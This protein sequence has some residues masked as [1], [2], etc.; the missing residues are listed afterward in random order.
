M[1][2]DVPQIFVVL[3]ICTIST[4]G[5]SPA[6]CLRSNSQRQWA[7]LLTKIATR[8]GF[9]QRTSHVMPRTSHLVDAA[10]EAHAVRVQ[11]R[12]VED[13]PLIEDARFRVGVLL[14][15][16]DAAAVAEER[17]RERGDDAFAVRAHAPIGW[18][19][20]RRRWPWVQDLYSSQAHCYHSAKSLCRRENDCNRFAIDYCNCC[21]LV[22]V[23]F[24]A[25]QPGR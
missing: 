20:S 24:C 1:L 6:S 25:Q 23:A 2:G 16:H 8:F 15:R 14:G 10:L 21:A 19:A 22:L 13:D 12:G 9:G 7:Y 18:P 3:T 17:L 4:P 11:F 5:S